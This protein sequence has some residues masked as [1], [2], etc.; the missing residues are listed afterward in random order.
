[1]VIAG[2]RYALPLA[3]VLEALVFDPAA[4]RTI[5]G[6]EVMTLRGATL[7]LCRLEAL[8]GLPRPSSP[9]AN[10][11]RFVVVVGVG[12]HRLGCVVD[13][14]IGQQDIVIKPLGKSLES[15]RGFA[16]ATELG[17]QNV[18]LVI[19]APAIVEEILASGDASRLLA[20][21]RP[22]GGEA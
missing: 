19:D 7:A 18:G 6:R 4:V 15:V 10:G 11:R 1:V 14:L 3:S 20:A 2:R 9:N 5:E 16:G 21:R 12:N 13:Q 17:D 22:S 8:F